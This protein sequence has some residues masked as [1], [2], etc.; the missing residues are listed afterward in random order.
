MPK[1]DYNLDPEDKI[2][3]TILDLLL[4]CENLADQARHHGMALVIHDA[5]NQCCQLAADQKQGKLRKSG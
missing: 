2:N 3:L 1:N 4:H 5:Y